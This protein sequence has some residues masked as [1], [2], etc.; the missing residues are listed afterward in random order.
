MTAGL[1]IS[2][3][4]QSG[5]LVLGPLDGSASRAR[6]HARLRAIELGASA[7]AAGDIATVA[8]ELATN[9]IQASQ[10]VSYP[11]PSEIWLR[12]SAEKTAILIEVGDYAPGWPELCAP[13][14][15][16][17]EHGRGLVLVAALSQDWG[18]RQTGFGRPGK[19]TWAQISTHQPTLPASDPLGGHPA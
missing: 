17:V 6:D 18:C 19:V 15:P 8:C 11:V 4:R 3:G 1:A 9:A 10:T 16:D 13:P 14:E 7:A 2:E 12:L 5:L